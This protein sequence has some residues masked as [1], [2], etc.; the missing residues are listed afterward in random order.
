[1]NRGDNYD[2]MMADQGM[3]PMWEGI[4]AKNLHSDA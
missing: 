3:R 1:M 2:D 4:E